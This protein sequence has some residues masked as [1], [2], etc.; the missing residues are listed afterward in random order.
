MKKHELLAPILRHVSNVGGIPQDLAMQ[1]CGGSQRFPVAA[2]DS[3][4]GPAVDELGMAGIHISV[5]VKLLR[6]AAC[7]FYP[8][9]AS[10][11]CITRPVPYD[12]HYVQNGIS[13]AKDTFGWLAEAV[14]SSISNTATLV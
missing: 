7:A 6:L 9:T 8:F 5:R 10:Q 3:R 12:V 14:N 2:E 13:S 11:M 4:C 1:G